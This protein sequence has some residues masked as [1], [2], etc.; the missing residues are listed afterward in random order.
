MKKCPYCAEEIQD[1][2]IKCKHCGTM[3]ANKPQEKWYFRTSALIIAFLCFGPFML[4]LVWFNPH[5][6]RTAKIIISSVII[7]LSYFVGVNIYKSL[8][9]INNYY[10]TI[11]QGNI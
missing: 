3:L 11:L 1:E 5:L 6:S 9:S 8:K 10:Q 7:I 2:A 4:P